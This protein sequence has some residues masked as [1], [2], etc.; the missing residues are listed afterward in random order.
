MQSGWKGT[1]CHANMLFPL[2]RLKSV[3]LTGPSQLDHIVSQFYT[4]MYKI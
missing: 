1:K 4:I 2:S 3:V